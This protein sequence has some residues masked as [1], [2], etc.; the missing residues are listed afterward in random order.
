[1]QRESENHGI[2]EK[3]VMDNNIPLSDTYENKSGDLV[4]VCESEDAR[5][6]LKT[7]VKSTHQHIGMSSP[8]PKKKPGYTAHPPATSSSRAALAAA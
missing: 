3:A 1:M 7:A 5:D 8:K 4:I 6:K 2:I